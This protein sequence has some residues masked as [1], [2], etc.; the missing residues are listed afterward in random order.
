MGYCCDTGHAHLAGEGPA[1]YVRACADRLIGVHWHDSSGGEDDHL[2]P[3]LGVIDW[4]VFFAA[5]REVGYTAPITVEA[6][7]PAGYDLGA[8]ATAAR[9][10]LAGL[11]PVGLPQG[12]LPPAEPGA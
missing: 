12:P 2:F 6:L 11:R 9:E 7:P 5:L 10:T 4:E 8:L 1:A 3:G